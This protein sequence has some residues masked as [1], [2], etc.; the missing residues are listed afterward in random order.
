[1]RNA[2]KTVV[3]NFEGKIL[4]RRWEDD[5]KMDLMEIRLESVDW[6]HLVLYI[7][8]WRALVNTVMNLFVP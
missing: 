1:M 5:I 2:Y 4:S 6:I 8:R 7:D 3:R